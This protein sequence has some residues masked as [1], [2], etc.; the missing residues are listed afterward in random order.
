M[1][2]PTPVGQHSIAHE[3]DHLGAGMAMTILDSSTFHGYTD[4]LQAYVDGVMGMG[5][6]KALK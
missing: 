1:K 2:Q 3:T 5:T 4:S 6:E